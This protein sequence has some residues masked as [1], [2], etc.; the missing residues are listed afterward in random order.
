MLESMPLLS[1]HKAL[2]LAIATIVAQHIV[3]AAVP[4]VP[5]NGAFLTYDQVK[6]RPFTVTSDARSFVVDGKRSILLSGSV[7]PPRVAYSDWDTVL[8]RMRNDGLNMVQIYTFWNYHEMEPGQY[9]FTAG[10]RRDLAGF[11]AKAA[12]ANLFVDVRIGPYVCAEWNGG[13]LPRW[14]RYVPGFTCSRCSDPVSEI[15]AHSF[16]IFEFLTQI[17][18]CVQL[19]TNHQVWQAQMTK[20]VKKIAEVMEPF[21]ARKGGPIIMAQI[22]NELHKPDGDPYVDYCGSLVK[23][24]SLDIPW[25]MCNG[26][27]ANNTINT[28]NGPDC[29]GSLESWANQHSILHPAQPMGWT[30]DWSGFTTWT[31]SQL[32]TTT[33]RMATAIAKW[34]AAGGSH[35]NYYMYYGGNHI[36]RWAAA[37]LVNSYGDDSNLHSDLQPH[38]PHMSHLHKLHVALAKKNA[39]LMGSPVQT[40]L[41]KAVGNK[42]QCTQGT[43]LGIC[44]VDHPSQRFELVPVPH[45]ANNSGMLRVQTAVTAEGG[46]GA[47]RCVAGYCNGNNSDVVCAP[48][49][50]V[51]CDPSDSLQIWQHLDNSSSLG[52]A[53]VGYLRNTGSHQCLGRWGGPK[54]T[55][56]IAGT[57]TCKTGWGTGGM[58]W[59]FTADGHVQNSVPGAKAKPPPYLCVE[60]GHLPTSDVIAYTYSADTSSSS[61]SIGFLQNTGSSKVNVTFNTAELTLVSGAI[62]LVDQAGEILFNTAA[63]DMDVACIRQYVPI[64]GGADLNWTSTPEP[65]PQHAGT[66]AEGWITAAAPLEQL[67]T[68][69]DETDYLLYLATLP[70]ASGADSVANLTIEAFE[71]NA[72]VPFVNGQS[73]PSAWDATKGGSK[74]KLTLQLPTS[75]APAS[76][77]LVSVNLGNANFHGYSPESLAKGIVGKVTWA[78]K[79]IAHTSSS[80]A[81]HAGLQGEHAGLPAGA[82]A[83][84]AG[85]GWAPVAP[86]AATVASRALT[87]FKAGFDDPRPGA[88]AN[89]S[90]LLDIRGL[91]RGHFYINGHDLGKYWSIADNKQA[92]VQRYYYIP[93]DVLVTGQNALVL[94]DEDGAPSLKDVQIV[95]GS[96]RKPR[97]GGESCAK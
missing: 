19:E 7:H 63:I 42:T 89:S 64:K 46:D 81:H 3:G 88:P 2:V 32:D 37:S 22:E 44:K 86:A 28:C 71:S 65:I 31:G 75:A 14:L 60:D 9:N 57:D 56:P 38:E 79:D 87:W 21:L 95:Y 91:S 47:G 80:W 13:G 8:Q 67:N 55:L 72:F 15:Q 76:L 34:F 30:E 43:G 54:G 78:G 70:A 53:G 17:V 93:A 74:R 12:A 84:I 85:L 11:L 97:A 68:T 52:E 25:V 10:T 1:A 6:G 33:F 77:L 39:A 27:S 48:N 50:I 49:D 40:V 96:T 61:D 18:C 66:A 29:A 59:T 83:G 45:S 82:P 16:A 90:L 92:L 20:F 69:N 4:C 94:I 62:L 36:E 41:Y 24:L 73:Y 58:H 26:A 23:E 35:H 5:A 51:P